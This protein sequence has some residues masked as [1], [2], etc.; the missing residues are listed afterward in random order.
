MGAASVSDNTPGRWRLILGDFAEDSLPIGG[1]ERGMDDALSFLYRREYGQEHGVR[2]AGGRDAGGRRGGREAS[3]LTIPAW[4]SKIRSLFPKKTVEILQREALN[5]YRLTELLTDPEILKT[6]EPNMDLQKNILTFRHL[7][8]ENVKALA[9]KIVEQ[10]V[11]E[12]QKKLENQVRRTFTGKKLPNSS[13]SYKVHRNFDIKRTIRKN[14]KNYSNEHKTIVPDR[15]Y[16]NQNIKRYNPWHVII[17]VDESGSMLDSV[18]YA[19]VMAGIFSKLPFLSIKLVVFDTSLVD[20]SEHAED[21]V[22]ILMKVQLG[23]GTDIHGALEYGKKLIAAPHKT[24]IVLV[25][26]LYEGGDPRRMLRSCSDII[27]SGARLLVLT[28]LD[29]SANSAYD[30]QGAKTLASMGADVAAL[31]PDELAEWI[32]KVIS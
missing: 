26:D 2:D 6:M 4:I 14:L 19:S 25:S 11:R 29:Y 8:P 23:G 9:Y 10:V 27:E 18:I 3:R 24:I 28:A 30:K 31:T 1:E 16:F 17:L 22:G 32:G 5:K 7:M 13:T 21:P 12:I 20:L 15:L